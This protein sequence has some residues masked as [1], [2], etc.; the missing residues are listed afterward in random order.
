MKS[1][2]GTA[3]SAF[4]D[5]SL[6]QL[7]AAARLPGSGISE[8]AVNAA[9]AFIESAKPREEIECALVIQMAC[10][11]VAAMA[12]LGYGTPLGPLLGGASRFTQRFTRG[13]RRE[14]EVFVAFTGQ[15]TAGMMRAAQAR[16]RSCVSDA[17][18]SGV[19]PAWQVD[20]PLTFP[21]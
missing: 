21:A 12:V 2:F 4:V 7:I 6:F 19:R 13:D 1:A 20:P 15:F 3:S 16:A 17:L 10:T 11:H 5:A 14:L 8:V 18:R 9:L